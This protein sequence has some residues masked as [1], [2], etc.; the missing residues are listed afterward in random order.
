LLLKRQALQQRWLFITTACAIVLHGFS[1]Y[2]LVLT[3]NG[4]DLAIS[5]VTSLVMFSINLIVLVSCLRKPVHSLFIL[6][7][8]ISAISMALILIYPSPDHTPRYL[9]VG[10]GIHIMLSIVAYSLLLLAVLQ[11]L[12]LYWQNSQLKK[13]QLSGLIKYFPPLQTMEALM[14]ELVWVGV[15]L[16]A[17]GIIIGILYIDDMFGQQLAHKTIL[18]IIAWCIFVTLLWGRSLWGWRGN[19]AVHWILVGFCVLMLGYFGSKL[20]LEVIL[21]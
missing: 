1:I 18:S 16:L 17:S 4:V 12:L 9:G 2:T 15:I 19:Q 14:F 21:V 10:I 8:P 11:A 20:V 13:R 3:H 5:K 7:L 6:L